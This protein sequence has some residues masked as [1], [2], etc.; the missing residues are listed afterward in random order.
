MTSGVRA[1]RCHAPFHCCNTEIEG[2][3]ISRTCWR[4]LREPDTSMQRTKLIHYFV[5]FSSLSLF[6]F[7]C[8]LFYTSSLFAL[9]TNGVKKSS[10]GCCCAWSCNSNHHPKIN[11]NPSTVQCQLRVCIIFIFSNTTL[12][13]RYGLRRA[14]Y[15]CALLSSSTRPSMTLLALHFKTRMMLPPHR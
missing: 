11:L 2:A 10:R 13:S 5:V 1:R 6:F 12:S 9:F 8:F 15:V 4:D 14:L 7:C 3:T